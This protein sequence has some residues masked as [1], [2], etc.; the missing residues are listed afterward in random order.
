MSSRGYEEANGPLS[1]DMPNIKLKKQ[2]DDFARQFD[3]FGDPYKFTIE[4]HENATVYR[5]KTGSFCT[6]CLCFS[7][8]AF[9]VLMLGSI[10]GYS[11]F[12][13]N[14]YDLI[15]ETHEDFAF[16]P[17]DSELDPFWFAIALNQKDQGGERLDLYPY[18]SVKV[19]IKQWVH[20]EEPL[21]TPLLMDPC[22][23]EEIGLQEDGTYPSYYWLKSRKEGQK[24]HYPNLEQQRT[25]EKYYSRMLCPLKPYNIS[26]NWETSEAS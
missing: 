8:C 17:A 10:I 15:R 2:Y 5:S 23:L 22:P 3:G 24:M 4:D 6:G 13:I 25:V 21:W 26:G 16:P 1:R 14:Q 18:L 20:G 19:Y 7:M 12:V 11:N 9:F